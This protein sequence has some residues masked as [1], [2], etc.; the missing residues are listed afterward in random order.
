MN[1]KP[2]LKE[3]LKEV[4]PSNDERAKVLSQVNVFLKN[5]NAEL[6]RVRVQ[7]K[8]VLGGSYAKDTWLSG[9]Y[10]VDVFVKFNSTHIDQNLSDLLEKA[11][12]KWRHERIHGSRDYFWVRNGIKYEIVPV[13]DIRRPEQAVNVTD[14]SPHHVAWVNKQGKNLKN[15]IRLAKKFCKGASCYGAESY[16]RGFSGH[17]LDILVVHYKG[18][19]P[20][21][22]A[23]RDWKPKVVLDYYKVHK[24]NALLTLNKSKIEGPLILI[25]PVQP[26][27]N[28][29]AALTIENFN[30][31]VI[32]ARKF[33]K[34][35]L[36]SAFVEKQV[37]L[38]LLKKKGNLITVS[39]KTLDDKEDVAGTKFVRAFEHVR[40]SLSD[41]K[42]KSSGWLWDRKSSGT[43]WFLLEEKRL[44]E[45]FDWPGPPLRIKE[46]VVSFKRKYKK[47]FTKKGRIF[48][49]VKRAERLPSQ[50]L[51]GVLAESYIRER[52][53]S[54]K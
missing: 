8:A 26:G 51:R 49:K 38:N 12:R 19:I 32:A 46:A 17:V 18:F 45:F 33:L 1:Y 35:P 48:A 36:K 22:K 14:F 16:I 54:A 2:V 23:A 9:D 39:V 20:L 40:D 29:A 53:K 10:D 21:L 44:S 52:V 31:F 11:L 15:D 34:S 47:T 4:V 27:R 41:F 6:K 3:V 7:A 37:D 28:A 30:K 5:L 13:L 42:V 25:D 50:I 24:G 43:W